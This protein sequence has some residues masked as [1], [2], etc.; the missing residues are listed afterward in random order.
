MSLRFSDLTALL[1]FTFFT[2]L[3]QGNPHRPVAQK[4]AN[5]VIFRRF[6]GEGVEFFFNRTLLTPAQNFDAHLLEN[7]NLTSTSF[8][9]SVSFISRSFF[10]SD[11]FIA[12]S[13]E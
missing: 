5:E 12:Y 2:I 10:E 9:F 7:T 13:N 11:G 6:Q 8:H 1:V 4:V 3:N